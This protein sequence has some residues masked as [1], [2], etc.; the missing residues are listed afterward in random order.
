MKNY[1]II[2]SIVLVV[3]VAGFFGFKMLGNKT[4]T[5]TSVPSTSS[6][7]AAETKS[8]TLVEVATHKDATS[9]WMAIEGNVYDVTGFVPQHP[10]EDAILLG[11]GKDATEMFNTRPNDGTTHSNRARQMLQQFQIGILA[12]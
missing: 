1:L 12:K 9:C 2:G 10:G 3:A 7:P 8:I 4:A 11:C 5:P 6:A